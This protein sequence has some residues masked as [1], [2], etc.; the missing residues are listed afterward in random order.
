M[1]R[2]LFQQLGVAPV[3]LPRRQSDVADHGDEAQADRHRVV[4]V[5]VADQRRRDTVSAHHVLVNLFH[6]LHNQ[7]VVEEGIGQ[8]ARDRDKAD[9]ERPPEAQA[10]DAEALVQ[11]V[12]AA[13]DLAQNLLFLLREARGNRALGQPRHLPSGASACRSPDRTRTAGPA[14][15]QTVH[16]SGSNCCANCVALLPAT[17][18]AAAPIS[19]DMVYGKKIPASV[20]NPR[21]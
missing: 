4:Q 5:H 2:T 8:V 14:V 11:V 12:R 9:D 17:Y 13:P 15:I 1:R 19:C 7:L 20:R 3:G 6:L 10:T 18:L 16:T 21:P